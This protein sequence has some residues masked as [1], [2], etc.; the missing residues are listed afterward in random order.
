MAFLDMFGDFF[1]FVVHR[2]NLSMS[3]VI[4]SKFEEHR[5]VKIFENIG[6]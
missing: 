4:P 3:I 6:S 2:T 1:S 5:R